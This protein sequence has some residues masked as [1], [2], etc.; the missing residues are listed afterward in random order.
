MVRIN[1][2]GMCHQNNVSMS[3][4]RHEVA[5]TLIQHHF[6]IMCLLSAISEGNLGELSMDLIE[7]ILGELSINFIAL[8]FVVFFRALI[9]HNS[10]C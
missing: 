6:D 8:F 4:Q 10:L 9:V 7:G 1:L 3:M 5:P 2:A